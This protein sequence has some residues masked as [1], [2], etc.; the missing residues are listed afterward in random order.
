ML[1]EELYLVWAWRMGWPVDE[2]GTILTPKSEKV[3]PREG[4]KVRKVEG[5]F[6]CL[7][8]HPSEESLQRRSQPA[9]NGQPMKLVDG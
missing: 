8:G 4:D 6:R 5:S 7:H 9:Q 1:S 2:L 3:A